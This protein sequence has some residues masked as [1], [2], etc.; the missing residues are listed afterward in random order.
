[1]YLM[2]FLCGI[3]VC[4]QLLNGL[5]YGIVVIVLEFEVG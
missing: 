4:V 2:L 3:E 1:M 5:G